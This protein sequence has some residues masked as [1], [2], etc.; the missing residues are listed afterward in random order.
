MREISHRTSRSRSQRQEAP[1]DQHEAR[2]VGV[3]RSEDS[4]G[5]RAIDR[6]GGH[7]LGDG[8]FR[9]VD[10]RRRLGP[11]DR[12]Q[13]TIVVRHAHETGELAVHCAQARE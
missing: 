2:S 1:L 6:I 7:S 11:K 4:V 10:E 13:H 3:H 5:L 9:G 8:P 12:L